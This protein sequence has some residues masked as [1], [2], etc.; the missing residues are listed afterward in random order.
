MRQTKDFQVPAKFIV[1]TMRIDNKIDVTDPSYDRDTWCRL[2][3]V[4]MVPGECQ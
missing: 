1:D 3:D 2:N 4:E